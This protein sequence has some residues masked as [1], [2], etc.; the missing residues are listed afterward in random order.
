MIYIRIYIYILPSHSVLVY[1]C[2]DDYRSLIIMHMKVDDI[3]VVYHDET[4]LD[5]KV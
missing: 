4:H 1:F 2:H 3:I 5:D